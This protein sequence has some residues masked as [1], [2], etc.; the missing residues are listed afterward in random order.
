MIEKD[1]L[2]LRHLLHA[3]PDISNQ[4]YGTAGLIKNFLAPYH[5][6]EIIEGIGGAG[7]AA[8]YRFS[9]KGPTVAIRC[10]LDALPIQETNFF[11]H[12]ATSQKRNKN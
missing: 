11:N 12:K 3:N 7:L 2:D 10:E 1:I 4:E 5:P 8:V 6:T 9:K